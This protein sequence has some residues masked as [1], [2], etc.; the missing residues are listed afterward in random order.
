M[1]YLGECSQVLLDC[2]FVDNDSLAVSVTL[3]TLVIG[4]VGGGTGLPAFRTT[5][6]LVDCYGAGKAKKLAEIMSAV[7]LAGEI[8]C[9]AAECAHEFVRAHETMGKNRPPPG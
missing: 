1:A 8:S 2:H 7:I 3:P 9:G 6:S 5:L 4:T